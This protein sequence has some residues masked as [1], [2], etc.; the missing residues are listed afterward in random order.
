MRLA[1]NA[2]GGSG[3]EPEDAAWLTTRTDDSRTSGAD[4]DPNSYVG[5][6][7]DA[8]PFGISRLTH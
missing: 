2:A 5:G 6:A 3:G 4:P 1:E 8:R 7:C